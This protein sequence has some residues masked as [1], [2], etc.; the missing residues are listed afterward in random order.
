M[1]GGFKRL[2][3]SWIAN[4][5]SRGDG[6]GHRLAILIYHRVLPAPDPLRTY[7]VE[8]DEFRAQMAWVRDCFKVLPLR[9]AVKLLKEGK[10]PPAAA[11][12][13]FD[14]GYRDNVTTALPILRQ[15]GLTATFF[16]A[17]GYLDG[18]I[19][20]N[21]AV[22]EHVRNLPAGE[23]DLSRF[24]LGVEQL[25]GTTTRFNTI[26]RLL[27]ALKH[28]PF[29]ERKVEVDE[30]TA[31]TPLPTDLMMTSDHL[32]TLVE[33]G[34]EVGGHTRLHPILARLSNEEALREIEEGKADL[35]KVIGRPLR[36]FAYPNG[37]PGEDYRQEHVKMVRAA[38]FEAAVSTSPGVATATTSAWELPRFTPWDK[39]VWR[40]SL[41]LALSYRSPVT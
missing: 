29:P 22:I 14:D 8:A 1:V 11:A 17:S 18:G 39:A 4:R 33:A 21:D 37:R 6:G 16:I 5:T 7:D 35:E 10:L 25:D 2:G 38:G 15:L 31:G 41:R 19:M 23:I 9:E 40:Y 28:R 27:K 12:I 24:D 13:T 3:I 36:L 30:L 20:W 34:M 26:M 32:H